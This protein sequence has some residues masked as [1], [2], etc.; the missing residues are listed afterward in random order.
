[1]VLVTAFTCTA[2]GVEDPIGC[3]TAA[4]P[5]AQP[6]ELLIIGLLYMAYP[7][8]CWHKL[9]FLQGLRLYP[10]SGQWLLC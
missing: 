2:A 8:G 7:S 10:I 5:D 1:M 3:I 4:D 9:I 6:F